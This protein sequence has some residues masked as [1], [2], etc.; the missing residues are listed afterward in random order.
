MQ[1]YKYLLLERQDQWARVTLHRPDVRNAF[2][3]RLIVELRDCVEKLSRD[4]TMRAVVLA[5]AGKVF[6]AGA[7]A[8]WMQESVHYDQEQNRQDARRIAQMLK[9]INEC[10]CPVIGRVQG[11]AFGGGLGLAAVCDMVVATEDAKFAFT[12]VKLGILPA[13]ISLFV[14]PK[15]GAT[16]ARRYFL[17][18]ETFSAQ[19]AKQIGL[20]HEVVPAEQLDAKVQEWV[21]ALL[22]NGPR[23]VR[24]AK[25]LIRKFSVLS[26]DEAL[27]F[28]VDTIARIRVSA[29]GQEG[30]RAFL[31]KRPPTWVRTPK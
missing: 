1:S 2:N 21:E 3:D 6:C 10:P 7:D 18:A 20:V 5:G 19:A 24:E 11:A 15:I 9:T 13:V 22:Q 17:T 28:C 25:A 29:E 16:Q 23:A 30:L 14:L 8:R 12:E 4:E 27:D 31:E 26:P